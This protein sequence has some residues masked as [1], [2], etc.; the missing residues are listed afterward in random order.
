MRSTDIITIYLLLVLLLFGRLLF[1]LPPLV[2]FY[3][4]L[5]NELISRCAPQMVTIYLFVAPCSLVF[6]SLTLRFSAILFCA[7]GLALFG[8]F[9]LMSPRASPVSPR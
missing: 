7:L 8:L 2:S 3:L 6:W 9:I 5:F 1:G 4:N